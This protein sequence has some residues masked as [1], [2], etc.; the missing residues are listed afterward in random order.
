MYF[1]FI[2]EE[3]YRNDS[4]PT[5]VLNQ[6]IQWGHRVDILEPQTSITCLSDLL[7][8]NY[9]AYVLKTVTG[10]PGLSILEAAEAVGIPT[11]NSSRAIRQVR[12]KAIAAALAHAQGIPMPTTYFVSDLHLLHQIPVE[13]FPLVIKPTNGSSCR[14]IHY[15]RNQAELANIDIST[16]STNYWLAQHYEENIGFDTKLYVAGTQV[17]AVA[18]RSP[19][20][21]DI[22]VE[23][24]T[25]SITPT[26]HAL[27]LRVGVLFGLDIYGL[28][29]VETKQG[30]M[31]VD[32]NDFPSFGN[33]P[34]AAQS[35][36]TSILE[37][38][39]RLQLQ[40]PQDA[41][42]RQMDKHRTAFTVLTA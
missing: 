18:K 27:A 32:I 24:R 9:D 28:D 31:V 6:L 12:D 30:P 25:I 8:K 38:T 34:E 41:K 15:I 1:C 29:V 14:N 20:H 39:Q 33:V 35:V 3:Q 37:A 42:Q 19:L 13:Q 26:L 23:K 2:L 22:E 36:A 21:P 4:M 10:G 5:I 7:S 40:H 11:I 17:F 16:H